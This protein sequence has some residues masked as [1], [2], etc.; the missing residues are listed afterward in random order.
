M[1]PESFEYHIPK[2]LEEASR[3]LAQFG[4]EGKILAGGHSLVP[5]MKLR[6][7]AP[8]HLIDLGRL[9]DL[10]YI[11]EADGKIEM[12]ALTTHFQIQSS[13]L[14]KEKC[15]LLPMTAREIGD[16]QVRNKGTLGGSL[17]H[18]DPAADWPAA[19]V[20]LDAELK[21]VSTTGERW[22]PASKFFMGLMATALN[23][24]EIVTAI[25]FPAL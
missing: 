23:P 16:V 4:G 2:N 15:P 10:K 6:L 24:G 25:R 12:G 8:K 20:A 1:I 5:M 19:A 18:A 22:V 7:A 3:L 17:A 13:S 21:A 14:L 11:R 9:T